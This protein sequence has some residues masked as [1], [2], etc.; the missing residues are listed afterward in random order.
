M[1]KIVGSLLVILLALSVHA[2]NATPF[3]ERTLTIRF[4]DESLTQV[5]K[6]IGEQ[7]GFTFS[8]KSGLIDRN[9]KITH[10]FTNKTVRE[11][12]DQLFGGT[13]QYRERKKH[14]ILTAAETGSSNGT[15]TVT[16]YVVDESTGRRVKN[17]SVYD[18]V[19]MSSAVTDK[20]GYFQL[21]VPKPSA[22]ELHLTVQRLNYADTIVAVSK[23]KQ[24]LLHIPLKINEDKIEAVADS[25]EKNLRK[26]WLGTKRVTASVINMENIDDT[27][28]SNVQFSVLPFVGTNH[29][30]SG[31]VVNRYSFNLIGGYALGV[32]RFE[33]AGLFNTVGGDV[34]GVQLSGWANGVGGETNGVQIAGLLNANRGPTH[35]AQVAGMLNFNWNNSYD[36]A[37]AGLVNFFYRDSRGVKVAGMS[38]ITVGEQQGPHIA[39]LFNFT[40]GN[41]TKAQVAGA[42]NFSAGEIDGVQVSGLLNV[43]PKKIRGAQVGF[44][45]YATRVK[46]SQIGFL[47]VA[48]SMKG[49]PVGFLSFVNRG[50]HKIEVSADEIFYT[51]L[52]FRTGVH[53]FYNIFTVGAKPD[54][55]KDGHEPYWTFGYGIGTSPKLSR[56]LYL[57]IDLTANQIMNGVSLN[58]LNLL[59]KLYVGLEFQ[60]ARKFSL[61]LGTTINGYVTDTTYDSYPELF[62]DYS[63]EIIHDETFTNDVNLKMWWGGKVGLRFL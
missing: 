6:K 13:L 22:E 36:F 51:N 18:P 3:L 31:N 9:K 19:S 5:L 20:Y 55:S 2:Q 63:P 16:G 48:D 41:V 58:Y 14:I 56:R 15:Q 26:F 29:K 21:E 49:V 24:G 10:E 62:T 35:G 39:G 34:T 37:G 61:F 50:Y 44:V 45:N 8:Y 27:L 47:N 43:A 28:Y 38:N 23:G 42:L 52:S 33:I 59:N 54:S 30:L 53:Q 12:L 11:I 60:A 1:K 25:I 46:G 32:S 4:E 17:V 57:N 7:G 40:M